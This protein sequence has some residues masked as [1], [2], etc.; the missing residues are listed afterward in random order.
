MMIDVIPSKELSMLFLLSSDGST[1]LYLA[2][3][4]CDKSIYSLSG[5]L[6]FI[7]NSMFEQTACLDNQ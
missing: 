6:D 4:C 1:V 3:F 7:S 5:S 2:V